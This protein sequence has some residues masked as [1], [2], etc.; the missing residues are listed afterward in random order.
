MAQ[1]FTKWSHA[2]SAVRW[3]SGAPANKSTAGKT[4]NKG[5]I[6]HSSF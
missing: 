1:N 2:K 3:T 4:K 5:F 6:I